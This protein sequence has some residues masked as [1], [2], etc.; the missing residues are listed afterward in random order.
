MKHSAILLLVL[1]MMTAQPTHSL[2]QERGEREVLWLRGPA[3]TS[4]PWSR[5]ED[6]A[7]RENYKFISAYRNTY[8]SD[9]TART[10]PE[11]AEFFNSQG[12]TDVLG[13]GHDAG[14]LVLR[15][16]NTLPT[17]SRLSAMILDGV[18]NQGAKIMDKL[19]TTKN[20]T[21]IAQ[22]MVSK[23]L[24]LRTRAQG[25]HGCR[26]LEATQ[27][28]LSHFSTLNNRSFY[29]QLRSTSP[30]IQN[31]GLPTIPYAVIWGNENEEDGLVLTRLVSS[32]HSRGLWG[33][34]HEY[35]ECYRKEIEE[36]KQKEKDRKLF[37]V[38][39][40]LLGFAAGVSQ[41]V[42]GTTSS[43]PNP[44][45]V[46]NGVTTAVNA[47]SNGIR[48]LSVED[49]TREA[50]ECELVHQALNA[51]WSMMVAPYLLKEGTAAVPCLPCSHC[52]GMG[53]GLIDSCLAIC[54]Y[55]CEENV[56]TYTYQYYE[57]EPHDGLLTRSEQLLAGA[58]KTYEAQKVNHFQEQFWEY[59][60]I[61]N[62]FQDLFNGGAGAA[63]V[64]PK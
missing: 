20:P 50:L 23:L 31:L 41:V 48:A 29:G 13:I 55:N 33:Q 52:A 34:D 8:E 26:M 56:E 1:V 32:W 7:R 49:K 18:P 61:G 11:W 40:S 63:F 17:N 5:A 24:D 46:I 19:L 16:M 44:T 42:V 30:V 39:G 53:P 62:A 28:W 64:V 4:A 15:Y 47:I 36:A 54:S 37:D 10:I 9:V 2:S 14:G 22:D 57:L 6:A 45:V 38:I 58:A 25:C 51:Q 3:Q 27:R 12:G 60:P 59:T 21:S 43:P 35:L